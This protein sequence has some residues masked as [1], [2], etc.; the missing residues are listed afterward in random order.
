M[1]T[2]IQ[3]LLEFE[4]LQSL[5]RCYLWY[6]NQINAVLMLLNHFFYETFEQKIS[7]NTNAGNDIFIFKYLLV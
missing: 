7:I 3:Y 2:I 6:F 4:K 1:Y 5:N